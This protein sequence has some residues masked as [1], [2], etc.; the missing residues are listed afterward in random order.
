MTDGKWTVGRPEV[1]VDPIP[2]PLLQFEGAR[3]Q[4]ERITKQDTVDFGA[5]IAQVAMQSKTTKEHKHTQI[6]AERVLK[7]ASEPLRMEQEG[8]IEEVSD[9]WPK[10]YGEESRGEK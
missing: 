10:R 9:H 5:T 3:I 2:I 7:N 6:A 1:R 8:W 4:K